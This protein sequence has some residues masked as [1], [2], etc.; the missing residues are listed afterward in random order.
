[1]NDLYIDNRIDNRAATRSPL[2]SMM[3]NFDLLHGNIGRKS[4]L[5]VHSACDLDKRM[6]SD[7]RAVCRMLI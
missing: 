4:R 7:N 2:T 5:Y 1:M 3:Y 6:P